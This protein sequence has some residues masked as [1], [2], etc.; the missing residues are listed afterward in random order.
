MSNVRFCPKNRSFT[1]ERQPWLDTVFE[2][3]IFYS[4]TNL[5]CSKL[6]KELEFD[7]TILYI[8]SME[9]LVCKWVREKL[10]NLYTVCCRETCASYRDDVLWLWTTIAHWATNRKIVQNLSQMMFFSVFKKRL[11]TCYSNFIRSIEIIRT[12]WPIY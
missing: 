12:K 10:M 8:H 5:F 7:K 6:Q 9:M 4:V 2:F 11:I 1:S 3:G